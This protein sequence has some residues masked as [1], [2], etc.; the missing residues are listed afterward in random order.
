LVLMWIGA[1]MLAL[2][3]AEVA[4][5]GITRNV[6][7][8]KIADSEARII[9]KV[10]E[11]REKRI[12]EVQQ[13]T[14]SEQ[15]WQDAHTASLATAADERASKAEGKAAT[16]EIKAAVVE[17]RTKVIEKKQR[18]LEQVLKPVLNNPAIVDQLLV[19]ETPVPTPT[20][21]HGGLLDL[22][23]GNP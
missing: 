14:R 10:T 6:V 20:P 7:S 21:K 18:H 3:A 23:R 12:A 2:G 11:Q 13:Q 19:P 15:A 4:E 22:L 8:Q 16:A 17:K 9:T 5:Q 1:T